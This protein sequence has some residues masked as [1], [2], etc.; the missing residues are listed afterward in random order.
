MREVNVHSLPDFIAALRVA[1]VAAVCEARCSILCVRF[2]QRCVR[3]SIA[4]APLITRSFRAPRQLF[5][6]FHN[7]VVVC[8]L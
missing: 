7:N 6:D 3:G 1:K 8:G 4:G 2:P 5:I